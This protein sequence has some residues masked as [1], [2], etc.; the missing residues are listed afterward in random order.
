MSVDPG[1]Q[2]SIHSCITIIM[3]RP[4]L[5]LPIMQQPP[6]TIT[7]ITTTPT[8]MPQLP[9]MRPLL[10]RLL[11]DYTITMAVTCQSPS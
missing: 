5:R 9:T 6:T 4:L 8:P 1:N 10:L 7:I 2:S 3:P 11:P